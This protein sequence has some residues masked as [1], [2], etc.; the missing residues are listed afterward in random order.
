M[1]KPQIDSILK[2]WFAVRQLDELTLDS[3]MNCWFGNDRA[4]DTELTERFAV[5]TEEALGADIAARAVSTA[6]L[7]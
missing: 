1:S 4:F 6:D 7:W 2:F 3:R 5:L